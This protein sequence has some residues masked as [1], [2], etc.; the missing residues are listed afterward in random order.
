VTIT[1][2]WY[3]SLSH[4]N[5]LHVHKQKKKKGG[6]FQIEIGLPSSFPLYG[7]GVYYHTI[8]VIVNPYHFQFF[9]EKEDALSVELMKYRFP[10]PHNVLHVS[11]HPIKSSAWVCLSLIELDVESHVFNWKLITRRFIYPTQEERT[12]YFLLILLLF[13]I[14]VEEKKKLYYDKLCPIDGGV[15]RCREMWDVC[16]LLNRTVRVLVAGTWKFAELSNILLSLFDLLDESSF[17]PSPFGQYRDQSESTL[18]YVHQC[19]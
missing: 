2:I 18:T 17:S 19:K 11:L 3:T 4:E 13:K 7:S 15:G 10:R 6:I 5:I 1:V 14:V 12:V 16:V 9:C 8:I